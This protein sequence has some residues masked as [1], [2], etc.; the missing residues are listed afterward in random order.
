M[1]ARGQASTL[2]FRA[3]REKNR[4]GEPRKFEAVVA[5]VDDDPSV[6]KGLERLIRSL[7]WKAETFASAQEFLDRLR[8]ESPSCLVL[9]LQLPGL[10]GLELQK[11]MA[12]AGSETPIIFL[13]GHG[14]VPA[15]VRA[16]KAGAVEF[17]TKPVK[18]EDLSKA[19]QEAIERAR[20]VREEHPD[21]RDS[22]VLIAIVDDDASARE[23][24]GHLIRSLGLR[25]ETFAS[26][27][28]FLDRPPGE[29][30]SCLVLDLELPGLSGLDLQKRMAELELK[31]PIVFVTGHANIPA[32]VQAI[33]AGAVEFLTKPLEEQELLKAIREAIERDRQNRR[34]HAE[35]S[36]LRDRILRRS[37]TVG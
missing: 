29:K 18:E 10:S 5:V 36:D 31:I 30:P 15:S 33:K 37:G 27:K 20:R 4:M 26:A 21:L 13:T 28:E 6:R 7:G 14:D 11:R 19:I 22:G 24:L 17:L 23:G 25:V 9:D 12:A 35:T 34:Q 2:R 16:M 32:S 8:T 1:K 3:I